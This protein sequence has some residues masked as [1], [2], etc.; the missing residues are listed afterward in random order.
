MEFVDVLTS[1]RSIRAFADTPVPDAVLERLLGR[2]LESPSWSNTQPY[3]VAV[4]QGAVLDALKSELSRRFSAVSTLQ[5]G[6]LASKV[7]ATLR[8]GVLPDGDY[9]PILRYPEDLQP[10]RLA[11]GVG[12]YKLLGIPRDDHV[13]RDAQMARNF[14]FFDAPTALFVFVHEGLGV[15]S[16]LDAGI[17]LQSLMLAATDEGLG[18]CAQGALALWR[19]PVEAHF[20][21]PRHY[22]LLCGVSLGYPL[23]VPVNGF[24]PERREVAEILLP[25]RG[26]GKA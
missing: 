2:A 6:S 19:S 5:R 7:L 15:Y 11:T 9:K 24:R 1:R 12:L 14:R 16:A 20:D 26:S 25:Q 3:K 21:I 23:A 13:A 18:S 4:A 22:K 8:G 10:R 17:F